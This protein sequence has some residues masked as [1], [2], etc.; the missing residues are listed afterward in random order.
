MFD[1]IRD[2]YRSIR[3]LVKKSVVVEKEDGQSVDSILRPLLERTVL[4]PDLQTFDLLHE[5]EPSNPDQCRK[6]KGFC[7]VPDPRF[8]AL[9]C[10]DPWKQQY[11]SMWPEVADEEGLTPYRTDLGVIARCAAEFG[12]TMEIDPP[13]DKDLLWDCRLTDLYSNVVGESKQNVTPEEAVAR[14]LVKA[15][16]W[17]T[18]T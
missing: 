5:Y 16:E 4:C 18:T 9:R 11:L 7:Y 8:D 12:W 2:A 3:G 1:N 13:E 14:A 17:H 6:C 10:I 15:V